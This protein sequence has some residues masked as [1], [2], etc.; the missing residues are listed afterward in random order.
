MVD[1]VKKGAFD[2]NG[3]NV[4]NGYLENLLNEIIDAVATAND[5]AYVLPAA[6]EAAIGGVKQGVAVAD[7]AG[8]APTAAE[9]KALL[10]SLR[11]SGAIA[12]SAE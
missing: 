12:T 8:E 2:A 5:G 6:T 3:S 10:D 7:A 4:G 1:K 11:T 9:F